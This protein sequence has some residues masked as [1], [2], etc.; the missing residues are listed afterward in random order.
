VLAAVK[1]DGTLVLLIKTRNNESFRAARAGSLREWHERFGHIHVDAIWMMART[2]AVED[3][4]IDGDE[5]NFFCE[6][7]VVVRRIQRVSGSAIWR[8]F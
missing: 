5:E 1:R 6:P 7:C 3:L 4:Q 8:H 2:G